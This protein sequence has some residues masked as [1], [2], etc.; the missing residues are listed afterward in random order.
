[1]EPLGLSWEHV[2]SLEQQAVV[3]L[4]VCT[5]EGSIPP[6]ESGASREVDRASRVRSTLDGWGRR[7]CLCTCQKSRASRNTRSPCTPEVCILPQAV[8]AEACIPAPEVCSLEVAAEACTPAPEVCT[9][10]VAAVE[11][12]YT[13]ARG[14]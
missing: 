2:V 12:A 5:R 4:A 13:L 8:A 11:E 10:E 9:L 3:P 14:A 6:W 1:M 7:P